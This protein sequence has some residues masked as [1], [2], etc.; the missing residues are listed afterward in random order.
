MLVSLSATPFQVPFIDTL[1]GVFCAFVVAALVVFIL[2]ALWMYRDAES[3]GMSGGLWVVLLL[4]ASLF[5]SFI[6]GLIVL[7]I[8]FVVR[9]DHPVG[10]G[11]YAGYP[12]YP[13]YAG[14]PGYPPPYAPPGYPRAVGTAPPPVPPSGA[15]VCRTCGAPLE[16]GGAFCVRCGARN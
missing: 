9:S 5:A 4:V 1:F 16:P 11:R 2:V 15:G 10:Y 13:G 7:V 14:Y 6:G 12:G 8:Y 3:R